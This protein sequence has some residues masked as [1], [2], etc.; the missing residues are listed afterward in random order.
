MKTP[1]TICVLCAGIMI[2]PVF[3][4]SDPKA[5]PPK[6]QDDPVPVLAVPQNYR[7][8]VRGR[9][10]PFLNPVPKPLGSATGLI[11]KPRP[12][13]LKGALVSEVRLMGIWVSSDPTSTRAVLQ[14]PGIK[15][16]I[17]AMRGDAL[18]DA[19]I[20]EIRPDMVIFTAVAAPGKPLSPS[21]PKTILKQLRLAGD[22]K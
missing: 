11:E 12:A 22:K 1:I 4:Q 6:V 8:E 14:V 7:Y 15:A 2:S 20:R 3:G 10:D 19:V 13:G 18:F 16:P 9:R 17:L 5:A 21:E